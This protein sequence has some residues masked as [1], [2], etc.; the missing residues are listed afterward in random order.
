MTV[1]IEVTIMQLPAFLALPTGVIATSAYGLLAK[2][3]V[4]SGTVKVAVS[5]ES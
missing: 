4:E 3:K 5:R 2:T 1:E